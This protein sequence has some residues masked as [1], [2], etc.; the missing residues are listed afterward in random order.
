MKYQKEEIEKFIEALDIVEVISEYVNLKKVGSNYKGLSP[1]KDERTPSF[2]VSP[3]KGIFKDFSTGIG[4]NAVSFYMKIND[5]SFIEAVEELAQKYNIPLSANK[6]YQMYYKKDFEVYYSIMEEALSFFKENIKKSEK[7]IKYMDERGFSTEDIEIYEIGF[8]LND[9]DSLFKYL[10]E[11]GYNEKDILDLNLAKT[12]YEGEI[13]DTFRNRI[14]FP[15][16]NSSK[17]VVAFGG[18]IIDESISKRVPKY[19]NSSDTKI[20]T[21][22]I[23]LFG[24]KEKARII[25]EKGYAILMEGYLDVLRAYKNGFFN[26]VASLGTAF[27]KQQA[28]L[29]KRYTENVVISYD[30]DEAGKEAVTKAGM[31]LQENGFKI[32][33]IVMGDN[34][35]EK[36]PDEF[37]KAHGKEGFVR[38]LKESKDFFDFLYVKYTKNLDLN[39]R[40]TKRNVVQQFKQYF[41]ILPEI[42][43][44]FYAEK[45]AERLNIKEEVI[46]KEYDFSG[47]FRE[48]ENISSENREKNYNKK[49]KEKINKYSKIQE[50]TIKKV[51]NKLM[52]N[53]LYE[54]LEKSTLKYL[55]KYYFDK[56]GKCDKLM[57][58]KFTTSR[59]VKIFENLKEF[60]FNLKKI[61]IELEKEEV[62]K[63]N[64][65]RLDELRLLKKEIIS[66]ETDVKIMVDDRDRYFREIYTSW[67]KRII[68][69]RIEELKEKKETLKEEIEKLEL[70]G[71][72]SEDSKYR[73]YKVK[74]GK[75]LEKQVKYRMLGLKCSPDKLNDEVINE[76]ETEININ[77]FNYIN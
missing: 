1:F 20:F 62:E 52:G 68:K 64:K 75:V 54:E 44:V 49:N 40:L 28:M 70:Q 59:Y 45:L 27:T 31:I 55:L 38:A 61:Q 19:L 46:L 32:K 11:K 37:M 42:D 72:N 4:G 74:L 39:D 3:V 63:L 67:I 51:E 69:N 33:C 50:E 9:K 21:K 57:N 73:E 22:G 14:M 56:N 36:D 16:Y 60:D 65:I 23:E 76:I 34:V 25:K 5:L 53:F 77:E 17:R 2:V 8:S 41:K 12:N 35:K 30:N 15:I 71:L 43:K 26:S 10:I 58:K 66:I 13:F 24:L 29:I 6:N 47:T 48:E 7:A 18:R